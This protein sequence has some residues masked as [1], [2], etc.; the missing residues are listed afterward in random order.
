MNSECQPYRCFIDMIKI[1]CPYSYLLAVLMLTLSTVGC[2]SAEP[3]DDDDGIFGTGVMLRGTVNENKLATTNTVNI[4][5]IDGQRDT[6]PFSANGDYSTTNLAGTGPWLLR[7]ELNQERTLFGIAYGDGARNINSFSDISLRRWFALQGLDPDQEFD[8][9]ASLQRLPSETEYGASVTSIFVLI[10]LVLSSYDVSSN[11][12]ISSQYASNDRGVDA[13]LNRNSVVLENG[14]ITFQLTDPVTQVRSETAT[15]LELSNNLLESGTPPTIPGSIRAVA[16]VDDEIFLA[17]E[18]SVDDVAVIGYVVVRDETLLGTTPYPQFLDTNVNDNASHDYVIVAIDGA[19][20]SSDPSLTATMSLNPV[21]DIVAPPAPTQLSQLSASN[22]AIRVS[23]INSIAS[24]IA[25]YRVY[26][27]ELATSLTPL[28]DVSINRSTDTNVRLD[29]TYCYRVS[30]IDGS[31]NESELSDEICSSID[32]AVATGNDV[33]ANPN[34]AGA[35]TVGDWI[36]ADIDS[37]DCSAL[38]TQADITFGR[39]AISNACYTVPETLVIGTGSTLQLGQGAILRFSRDA[40]LEI[41]GGTLTAIGT[42]QN[43]VIM[44]GFDEAPGSWAGVEFRSNSTGNTLDGVVVQYGG[45]GEVLAAVSGRLDGVRFRMLNTLLRRNTVAHSFN[46]AE[47]K[48]DAFTGNRIQENE[49]VGQVIATAVSSMLGNTEYINNTVNLLS[50]TDREFNRKDIVIPKLNIPI[51]WG[52]IELNNGSISI[53]PGA[54]IRMVAASEI[55]VRGEFTAVGTEDAPINITGRN[56]VAGSWKGLS[57]SGAGR[58]TFQNV[59]IENGGESGETSGAIE[60]DCTQGQSFTVDI[61]NTELSGSESWGI[62]AEGRSCTYNIGANVS[63][64]D[65]A[66]GGISVP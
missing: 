42:K 22:T 26:R 59:V 25:K 58:K 29:E 54:D 28:H 19:G 51:S 6:I 34:A 5:S 8:S 24:D 36:I 45:G 27:S 35:E 41:A 9:S 17:W 47:T 15:P 20:N 23:W 21:P 44:T 64:F 38:L 14:L 32:G 10:D 16:T 30:A 13:F 61:D 4:R 31:G 66:L 43:P 60:I 53:E 3:D 56:Q 11:D 37:L 48:I 12:V 55:V 2:T 63:I 39:L 49:E 65:T 46:S 40:G 50:I 57:L 52:G 62:F 7:V 1:V 18:P 33:E